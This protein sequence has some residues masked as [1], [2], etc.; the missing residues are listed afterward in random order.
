MC[1]T[2]IDPAT[3]WCEI[4]ELPNNELTYVKEK[5]NKTI[6]EVI[7][8]KSSAYV[9]GLFNE[10]WLSCY[11]CACVIYNTGSKFTLFFGN[12][13]NSFRSIRKPT[14]IMNPQ[15]NASLEIIHQVVTHMVRT[16]KLDMQDTCTPYMINKF[17]ANVGWAIRLPHHTVLGTTPGTAIFG[18]DMLFDIPH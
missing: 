17:I 5:D 8:D 18:R 11:I 14:T 9:A 13:C 2:I 10:S 16:S 1:L 6:T 4:A 7:I 15:A 12:L 3:S